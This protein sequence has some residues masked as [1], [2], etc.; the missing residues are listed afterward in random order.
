MSV[1]IKGKLFANCMQI[2]RKIERLI[3]T[4][5][6]FYPKKAITFLRVFQR[7]WPS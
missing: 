2:G 3:N 7:S 5:Q 6:K 1:I 4:T